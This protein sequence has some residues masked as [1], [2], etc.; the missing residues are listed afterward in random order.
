MSFSLAHVAGE[1]SRLREPGWRCYILKSVCK[2]GGQQWRSITSWPEGPETEVELS[3]SRNNKLPLIG[4]YVNNQV[5]K[6]VVCWRP[7]PLEI[8]I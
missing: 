6:L 5:N 7:F 4:Q 8:Y 1:V 3:Y 2:N